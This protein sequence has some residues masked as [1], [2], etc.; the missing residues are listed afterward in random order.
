VMNA[1]GQEVLHINGLQVK[2]QTLDINN[3]S[4]GIYTMI[5]SDGA[6][7]SNKKFIKR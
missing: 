3:L 7:Q 4:A 2:L 5:L 1:L 6:I